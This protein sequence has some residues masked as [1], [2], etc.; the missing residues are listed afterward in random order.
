MLCGGAWYNS[1]SL[2]GCGVWYNYLVFV[3]LFP[4]MEIGLAVVKCISGVEYQ[5]V[6]ILLA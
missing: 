3:F 5:F 1:L 2:L 6:K 4:S